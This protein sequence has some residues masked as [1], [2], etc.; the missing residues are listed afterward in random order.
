MYT[1]GNRIFLVWATSSNEVNNGLV[2]LIENAPSEGEI[3]TDYIVEKFTVESCLLHSDT[4]I[5]A[6]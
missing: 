3:F 5:R 1:I 2:A 4:I 6:F